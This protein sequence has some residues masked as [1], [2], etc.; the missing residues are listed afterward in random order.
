[1]VSNG[2]TYHYSWN[3]YGQ[4]TFGRIFLDSIDTIDLIPY[5]FII[6]YF[7]LFFPYFDGEEVG[8][9]KKM[10]IYH[11]TKIP[12]IFLTYESLCSSSQNI[13]QN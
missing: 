11:N 3:I 4:S 13:L 9:L 1:M 2:N 10:K 8:L 12:L 7:I 5:S 6:D